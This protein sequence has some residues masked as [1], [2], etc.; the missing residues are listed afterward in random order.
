MELTFSRN[1]LAEWFI[2]SGQAAV[3]NGAVKT[4]PVGQQG[5]PGPQVRGTL[6]ALMRPLA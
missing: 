1:N 6:Q 4:L 2:R 5:H 3:P